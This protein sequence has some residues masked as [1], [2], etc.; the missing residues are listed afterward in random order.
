MAVFAIL[1]IVCVIINCH[2]LCDCPL[3]KNV[4]Q[5]RPLAFVGENDLF[6]TTQILSQLCVVSERK[7]SINESCFG[8][9]K[10]ICRLLSFPLCF[11]FHSIWLIH[12]I[13][14]RKAYDSCVNNNISYKPFE[15]LE[16]Q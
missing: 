16:I 9:I 13:C 11:S 3:E 15:W 5:F 8:F 4:N 14:F 2:P 7:V 12:L 10:C 6:P 1:F